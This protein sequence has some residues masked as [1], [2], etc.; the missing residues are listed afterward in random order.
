MAVLTVQSVE[1]TP[2]PEPSGIGL[3]LAGGSLIGFWI[4]RRKRT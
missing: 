3:V 1:V 2:A 4:V